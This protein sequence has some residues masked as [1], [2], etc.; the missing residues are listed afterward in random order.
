VGGGSL[1]I[2]QHDCC[3]YL[4]INCINQSHY[5]RRRWKDREK[6]FYFLFWFFHTLS[7]LK[8]NDIHTSREVKQFQ[9][10]PNIYKKREIIFYSHG[11][12]TPMCISLDLWCIL[13]DEVYVDEV[14]DHTRPYML[15][16]MSSMQVYIEYM[17]ILIL[18]TTVIVL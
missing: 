16:R 9:L 18:Y 4:R 5:G 1:R 6:I 17:V 8:K 15:V 10:L 12:V 7:V 11:V 14:Y 3:V 2:R 13:F